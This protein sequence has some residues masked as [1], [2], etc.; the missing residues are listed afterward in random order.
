MR[1]IICLAFVFHL[2]GFVFGLIVQSRPQMFVHEEFGSSVRALAIKAGIERGRKCIR[3]CE[4]QNAID[5]CNDVLKLDSR[6]VIA[7]C[8]RGVARQ[9]LKDFSGAMADFNRTLAIAPLDAKTHYCRAVL[10]MILKREQA[11]LCDFEKAVELDPSNADFHVDVLLWKFD[12]KVLR[13]KEALKQSADLTNL[14]PQNARV[15]EMR[16]WL[17]YLDKDYES[18]LMDSNRSISIEPNTHSLRVRAYLKAALGKDLDA[19]LD[20]TE[21]INLFPSCASNFEERGRIRA[22]LND[23]D[24]ASNDFA[25]AIKLAPRDSFL[26]AARGR[27]QSDFALAISDFGKAIDLEP[28]NPVYWNDRGY[29][30]AR[31]KDFTG[32]IADF[33]RAISLK[34]DAWSFSWRGAAFRELKEFKLAIKDGTKAI[35]LQ[36][37]TGAFYLNRA[38]TFIDLRDTDAAVKDATKA[39]ECDN[40]DERAYDIRGYARR[41]SGDKRG[42]FDDYKTALSCEPRMFYLGRHHAWSDAK[43]LEKIQGI[44]DYTCVSAC[45]PNCFVETAA[46]FFR[47]LTQQKS[48]IQ[49]SKLN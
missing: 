1:N 41:L 30:R 31:S 33:D 16:A 17:K 6:N 46:M 44:F 8:N 34:K 23:D 22:R 5:A 32:A 43:P 36:P 7:L 15:W 29:A 14:Y 18:A 45:N 27:V 37:A 26:Y 10:L 20:L 12:H 21:A 49:A 25:E 38:I 42:A 47:M 2:L 3:Q 9:G 4:F 19:L 28:N 13:L 40:S 39:I 11:A 35:E 48:A 24:G